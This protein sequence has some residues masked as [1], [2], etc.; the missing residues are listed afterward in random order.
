MTPISSRVWPRRVSSVDSSRRSG[1]RR[2]GGIQRGLGRALVLEVACWARGAGFA[3]LTLTTFRHLAFNGPFYE[4]LGFEP[5]PFAL[6]GPEIRAT[7]AEEAE[8][9]L[10]PDKRI[11]M[12]LDRSRFPEVVPG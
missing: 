3:C 2:H 6:Q 5:I 7:L 12:R 1:Q 4:S 11:A 10:D 9:G 8:R